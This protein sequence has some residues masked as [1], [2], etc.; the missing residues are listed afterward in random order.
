MGA[1]IVTCDVRCGRN[2]TSNVVHPSVQR[3]L[4]SPIAFANGES[5]NVEKSFV[6]QLP[7]RSGLACRDTILEHRRAVLAPPNGWNAD[8]EFDR[9]SELVLSLLYPRWG[10]VCGYGGGWP[11]WMGL[12]KAKP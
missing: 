1:K 11:S 8:E 5:Q 2:I 12:W 6:D 9:I 4:P 10:G 3:W 7:T